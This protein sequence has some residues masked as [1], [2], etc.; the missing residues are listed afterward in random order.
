MRRLSRVPGAS[1]LVASA[2][3]VV[4]LVLPLFLPDLTFFVKTVLACAIVTGLSLFMGYAGQASLG[5]GAFVAVGALTVAVLTVRLEWPPLV[6]LVV[7]PAAAAVFATVVGFPLLRLR[8]HYLAF[9]TLAVLLVVQALMSTIPVLGG[10]IGIFGVPPLA[11]GP[12]EVRGQLPYAYI[13]LGV[14]VLVLVV[15]HA[16]IESRFGRG[17]RAF[18]G[19]ESAA[20]ASGVP[21]LRSKVSVFAL[22]A[23]CAGLAGGVTAFFT[24][25]VSQD[26][27]PPLE[28]FTYVIMAVI[29]GL[30]SR[31]GGVV[32]AVAVSLLLQGLSALAS[33][34]GLPPTAG[35][36]L[37]YAGYGVV[38]VAALL[39]MPRG[40]VPTLSSAVSRGVSARR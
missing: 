34:P 19:S 20:A 10:G 23:A 2:A 6:A 29:G 15:N 1:A 39:L 35:P 18:A 40:I 27:F 7:A 31:W 8:G 5:H 32:G 36:V 25:Y 37:Q 38:L 30:A 33:L 21:V 11:V 9:G 12:W 13:A 26:S 17:I 28:S 4:A 24:P 3:L 22:S 16:A 14:L